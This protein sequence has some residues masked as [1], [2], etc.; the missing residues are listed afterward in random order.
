M[1][2]PEDIHL[3]EQSLN[4]LVIKYEQYFLGIEKREPL[5]L[6]ETVD[7]LARKHS[8]VKIVNTMLNFKY[9]SLVSRYAS[10]RQY[11][12]RILRLMEE[13][14]YS[15]DRFRM[16]IHERSAPEARQH[17]SPSPR[18]E[19]EELYRQ[20]LEARRSCNL[21]TDKVSRDQVAAAIERQKPVIKA[22][23]GTDQVE[24]RVVVEDGVP[25]IKA[26]PRR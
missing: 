25:K 24:F 22:K 9:T 26:R 6:R 17:E 15:R 23:Y 19:A 14:K 7:R 21:P 1:G 16:A 3:F 5:R 11:W 18:D 13:G 4:E 20:F 10:Y 2:I 8:T 12:D